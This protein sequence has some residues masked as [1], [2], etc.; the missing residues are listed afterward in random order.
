MWDYSIPME[1]YKIQGRDQV[2]DFT[3]IQNTPHFLYK[4]NNELKFSN[5]KT[6]TLQIT[7]ASSIPI[8]LKDEF[9][10]SK[11]ANEYDGNVRHWFGTYFYV[12]G[13]QEIKDLKR[14]SND[15]NRRVFFINKIKID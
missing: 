5:H 4:S 6:D 3:I 9:E 8:K 15:S 1:D 12:W 2:A 11:S 13:T 10:E 7:E 14:R